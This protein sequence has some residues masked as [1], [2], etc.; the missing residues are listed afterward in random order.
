MVFSFFFMSTYKA[1]AS[2]LADDIVARSCVSC[3]ILTEADFGRRLSQ[4]LRS[5]RSVKRYVKMILNKFR[6]HRRVSVVPVLLPPPLSSFDTLH[7]KLILRINT[8]T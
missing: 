1:P 5:P 4:I 6:L 3:R 2:L 8:R 7:S